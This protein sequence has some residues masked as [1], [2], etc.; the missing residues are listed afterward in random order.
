MTG[1]GECLEEPMIYGET[2]AA[3][4]RANA[5]YTPIYIS[6]ISTTRERVAIMNNQINRDEVLQGE[7]GLLYLSLF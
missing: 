3:G 7:N 4:L 6:R 1:F 2:S 5:T